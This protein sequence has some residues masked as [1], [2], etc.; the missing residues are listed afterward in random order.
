MT[1]RISVCLLSPDKALQCAVWTY[2]QPF[3]SVAVYFAKA[4]PYCGK[5]ITVCDYEATL[6]LCAYDVT[7][8]LQKF[9]FVRS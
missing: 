6:A 7:S 4:V 1:I 2:R 9:F 3:S 8:T 5:K